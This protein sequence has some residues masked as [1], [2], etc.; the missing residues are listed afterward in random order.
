VNVTVNP[1]PA[2]PVITS[3]GSTLP[4]TTGLT[5]SIPSHS[6]STYAWSITNGTITAGQASTQI[7]FTAGSSGNVT[8][9]AVETTGCPS[10]QGTAL[11]AILAPPQNVVATASTTSSVNVSWTANGA[12][13]YKVL[14][15]EAGNPAFLLKSTS[16]AAAFLDNTVTAGSAYLYKVVAV[17]AASNETAASTQDLATTVL[18]TNDPIA[19]GV[20]PIKAAHIGELR[21]AVAA[22]RALAGISVASFTDPTLNYGA[23]IKLV[24]ITEL[25]TALDQARAPLALPALSYTDTSLTSTTPMRAAHVLELRDGVK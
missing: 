12:A 16:S 9:G 6:G 14:R 20:T 5:A 19:T 1:A 22:V 13:L 4:G 7:T 3:P 21:N 2:T 23:A 24:H 15:R 10:P 17:D 11:V 18:F 8:L 25:R